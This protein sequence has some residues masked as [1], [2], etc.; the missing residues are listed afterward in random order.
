MLTPNHNTTAH[1]HPTAQSAVNFSATMASPAE[2]HKEGNPNKQILF[3]FC[4]EW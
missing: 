3:R 1:P 2:D 4:S